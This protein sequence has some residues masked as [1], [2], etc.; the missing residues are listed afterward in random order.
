[1]VVDAIVVGA[2]IIGSS[3]AWR[4]AQAG[5]SVILV[6]AGRM[7][8]EA[9]WAAA[10]MLAPGGEIEG[11]SPWAAFALENLRCYPD[12]VT[13][14][15]SE[16]GQA[17]DFQR[18]GAIEVAL[19][20]TEWQTLKARAAVQG[21]VGI[22]ACPM[23]AEELRREIPLARQDIAGALF[24]PQDALVDP[25]GIMRVLRS[26]C[27]SRGVEIREG[28]S[29]REIRPGARSVEVITGSDTVSAGAAVLAA[30]AWS[31][32]I[33]V[34]DRHLPRAFPVRGHLSGFRLEHGSIGPILRHDHTYLLQRADGFTVA[35]TSSEHCGFDRAL[36]PA[37]VSGIHSRAADLLPTLVNRQFEESW[38]GFRPGV[39]GDGPVIGPAAGTGLWLAYGHYR[40]GILLAPGTAARVAAGIS[41]S[42]GK[43]SCAPTATR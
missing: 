9:S 42:S 22:P 38:L 7:G 34:R 4:V 35:G 30:G 3:I 16:T 21:K 24:Y 36:D 5:L 6:D 41:A 17:I 11:E 26:A 27:V 13:E 2:G 19:S 28:M 25:R 1:M 29:V 18:H 15:E 20:E 40:N 23:S 33:R 8:G 12:F 32:L 31:S 37:I 39:E 43:G 14:L 10:G